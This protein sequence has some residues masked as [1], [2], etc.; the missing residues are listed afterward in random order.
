MI[1]GDSSLGYTIQ[2]CVSANCKD[3]QM[4]LQ[5]AFYS[6]SKCFGSRKIV[7]TH[8]QYIKR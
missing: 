1:I 3:T 2:S 7:Q 4:G 5:H 6:M 8:F